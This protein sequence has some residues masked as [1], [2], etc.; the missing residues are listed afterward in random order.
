MSVRKQIKNFLEGTLASRMSWNNNQT[1]VASM[2][3]RSYPEMLSESERVTLET[4]GFQEV[5]YRKSIYDGTIFA[6][7]PYV[8]VGDFQML[9]LTSA[10]YD[11]GR[12]GQ[13][14][15]EYTSFMGATEEAAPEEYE[16]LANVL[17]TAGLSI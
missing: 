14:K 10:T 6:I 12:I 3:N 15:I 1:V 8:Q 5:L 2:N 16:Y 11:E 13:G 4:L 17:R 9:C 7:L